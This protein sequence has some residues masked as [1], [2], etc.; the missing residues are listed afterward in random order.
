MRNRPGGTTTS[1]GPKPLERSSSRNEGGVPDKAAA[2]AESEAAIAKPAS[3]KVPRT[4]GLYALVKT[5][6][7]TPHR[8]LDRGGSFG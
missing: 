6:L 2:W 7:G 3:A 5:E 4:A 1:A 8:R